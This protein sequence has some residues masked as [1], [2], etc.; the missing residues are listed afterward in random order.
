[1]EE[2][3]KGCQE[4]Q[5]GPAGWL[6]VTAQGCW[7]RPAGR[8]TS[9][10]PV[11]TDG[12]SLVAGAEPGITTTSCVVNTSAGAWMT[13]IV[14]GVSG[15]GCESSS[16]CE[17]PY[18]TSAAGHDHA[19]R[20]ADEG[21]TRS[22]VR[23]RRF[24]HDHDTT[25]GEPLGRR[26]PLGGLAFGDD[27]VRDH[28]MHVGARRSLG[29]EG[30]T[31]QRTSSAPRQPHTATSSA[32][33]WP[34]SSPGI[35]RSPCRR[36]WRPA[37]R[38]ASATTR[39]SRQLALSRPGT[40]DVAV[41]TSAGTAPPWYYVIVGVVARGLSSGE[42]RDGIP[43]GGRA[44]LRV[45]LGYGDGAQP[46]IRRGAWLV[47]GDDT[48]GVVPDRRCGNQRDRDR[49]SSRS[50][51]S[52]RLAGFHTPPHRHRSPASRCR[53]RSAWLLRPA[54][55]IDVAVV[56]LRA[57]ADCFDRSPRS[58]SPRWSGHS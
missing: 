49:C 7:T 37:T 29:T 4:G 45:I 18:A 14:G 26:Q 30:P 6:S 56:A 50:R 34:G 38:P 19:G 44:A 53:W 48:V 23:L 1:M 39:R 2:G 24:H 33:R 22:L 40:G 47:V 36:R 16:D 3:G 32:S 12:T 28:R 13:P 55:V 10:V 58:A 42:R 5:A 27:G 57:D 31:N 25:R 43:D 15:V 54:A 41:A 8:P 21:P 35:G 11:G 46:P 17:N 52:R 20:D 9:A 51:S